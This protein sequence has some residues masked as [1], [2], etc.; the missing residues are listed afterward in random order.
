MCVC[1]CVFPREVVVYII[2]FCGNVTTPYTGRISVKTIIFPKPFIFKRPCWAFLAIFLSLLLST[3]KP[4]PCRECMRLYV[5]VGDRK[6]ALIPG[7][8]LSLLCFEYHLLLPP[9]LLSTLS[10]CAFL[11]LVSCDRGSGSSWWPLTPPGH[12]RRYVG[13]WGLCW[14]AAGTL[15]KPFLFRS[16]RK[17]GGGRSYC[18]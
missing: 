16:R 2:A 10:P 15:R 4:L 11:L 14:R 13:R 9:S 3:L 1:V 6:S 12:L 18:L 5:C 8:S 17:T 7:T